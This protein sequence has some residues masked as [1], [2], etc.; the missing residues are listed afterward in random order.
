MPIA[1]KEIDREFLIGCR[2]AFFDE[3]L[4]NFNFTKQIYLE[5][6]GSRDDT[7]STLYARCSVFDGSPLNMLQ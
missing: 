4:A 7:S 2:S 3:N 1:Y 6:P 5:E